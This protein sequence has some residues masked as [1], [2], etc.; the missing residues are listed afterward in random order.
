MTLKIVILV[1]KGCILTEFELISTE[2]NLEGNLP[3]FFLV[4]KN[5][6]LATSSCSSWVLNILNMLF[7]A[8]V[9]NEVNA[10]ALVHRT[11]KFSLVYNNIIVLNRYISWGV[12][13]TRG[14]TNS[15]LSYYSMS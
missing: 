13:A 15:S 9:C 6:V 8:Y 4:H 12:V 14:A 7:I 10:L 5:W 1:G 11:V 3:S 2:F